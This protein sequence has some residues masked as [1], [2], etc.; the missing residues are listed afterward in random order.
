M[1]L[2]YAVNRKVGTVIVYLSAELMVMDSAA[3]APGIELSESD[4]L[5]LLAVLTED[6]SDD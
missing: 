3:P 4:L 2:A 5:H 6:G 1:S